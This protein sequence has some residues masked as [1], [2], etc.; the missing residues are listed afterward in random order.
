VLNTILK[1]GCA[2]TAIVDTVADL[3]AQYSNAR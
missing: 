1:P 2:E 3:E